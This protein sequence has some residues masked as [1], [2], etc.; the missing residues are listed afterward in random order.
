MASSPLQT[1]LGAAES[2]LGVQYKWGGNSLATGVDCSGLVQQ[3]F[4][5]AGYALPRVSADQAKVGQA[6]TGDLQPGDL[7]FWDNSSRNV[8]ADHVAIYIGN[9]MVLE[10][11][12][13]GEPV[14]V[15]PLNNGK[16][17]TPSAARRIIG[18][19]PTNSGVTAPVHLGPNAD[20]KYTTAALNPSAPAPAPTVNA[21]SATTAAP[22]GGLGD[23]LPPN[24]TPEQVDAYVRE[25]YS[26]MAPFLGNDEI[27]SL[28]HQ[29]AVEKW[30]G[31]ELTHRFE[32]TEYYRT[33]SP[34][35][36]AFDALIGNDPQGAGQLV[37]R[38]KRTIADL[39][40]QFGLATDDQKIGDAAKAA[41][42]AGYI[43]L[44]GGVTD[45]N[46]LTDF[47]TFLAGGQAAAT[48]KAPT[49]QVSVTAD[50]LRT[51]AR[52]FM[53]PMTEQDLTQ[54]ALDIS[55]G[56]STTDAFTSEMAGHAKSLFQNAPDIQKAIDEGRT[57]TQY[58]QPIKNLV[59]ETL[60]MTPDQVDLMAPR[61]QQVM[62][63]YDP[64]IK[65]NRPMTLGEAANWARSLPEFSK[66]T[67][68]RQQD[69]DFGLRLGSFLG[70]TA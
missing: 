24:A 54:R 57:P 28:G 1:V 68:Y 30:S 50:Q 63:T 33:H 15:A 29:A 19:M 66:T 39:F 52:S 11:Y 36:R 49:G 60:E 56:R 23:D 53:V 48:G 12:K 34:E 4:R 25:H 21:A 55:A 16:R 17:H 44:S 40:A 18:V 32:Q 13:T 7:L 6:V 35:S 8:G 45:Q 14:R 10:S 51:I 22:S 41:I 42:R 64:Q 38:A 62:Q 47:A 46:A 26:D 65:G 67:A 37:D 59:A 9:G 2:A 31:S 69:A 20:R 70:A 43:N 3:A 27:R 58:F 5:A 61:F